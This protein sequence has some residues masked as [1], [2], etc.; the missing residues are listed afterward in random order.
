M[1]F[2]LGTTPIIIDTIYPVGALCGDRLA[3]VAFFN[4]TQRLPFA[5][6]VHTGPGRAAAVLRPAQVLLQNLLQEGLLF[7]ETKHSGQFRT[8]PWSALSPTTNIDS[9][10]T[11]LI[12]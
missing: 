3:N 7:G 11:A 8:P 2:E 9:A 4:Q 12:C 10:Q 6:L 1:A 5:F